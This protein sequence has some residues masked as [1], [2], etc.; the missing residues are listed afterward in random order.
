MSLPLK[1]AINTSCKFT[2]VDF[3]LE[4]CRW[5]V[6]VSQVRGTLAL[7]RQKMYR[8]KQIINCS[9]GRCCTIGA[10]WVGLPRGLSSENPLGCPLTVVACSRDLS[11]TA[12]YGLMLILLASLY[13]PPYVCTYPGVQSTFDEIEINVHVRRGDSPTAFMTP[14]I[15]RRFDRSSARCRNLS[16]AN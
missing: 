16:R 2:I 11:K 6:H 1:F 7:L 9:L 15:G 10:V 4:T 5:N 14:P 12:I 3:P 8:S 13:F